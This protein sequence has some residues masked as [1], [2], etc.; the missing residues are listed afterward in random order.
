MLRR[1]IIFGSSKHDLVE[2][3]WAAERIKGM[4]CTIDGVECEV[5]VHRKGAT[6]AGGGVLGIIP[7]SMTWP[8]WVREKSSTSSPWF[9]S[10]SLSGSVFGISIR[11]GGY[12]IHYCNDPLQV[13]FAIDN[14]GLVRSV[15]QK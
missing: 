7:G 4:F 12:K 1:Q 8:G 15:A 5:V 11:A 3:D 2:P 9:N 10:R 13:F 14:Q 6:P